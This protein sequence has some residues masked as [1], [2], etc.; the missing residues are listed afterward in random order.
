MVVR[1]LIVIDLVRGKFCLRILT[2]PEAVIALHCLARARGY[3][4]GASRR[5]LPE[6]F[7]KVA[8]TGVATTTLALLFL[9][10]LRRDEVGLK[11][12][13]CWVQIVLRILTLAFNIIPARH[14]SLLL[15]A[16]SEQ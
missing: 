11:V 10:V 7:L 16:V 9:Q 8:L 2:L 6:R 15:L 12:G 13:A 3:S 4:L 5:L 1:H 14:L